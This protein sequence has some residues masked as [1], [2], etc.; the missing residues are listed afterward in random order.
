[1]ATPHTVLAKARGVFCRHCGKPI[2]LSASLLRRET[3]IKQNEAQLADEL[4]SKTFLARCRRCH[5]EAIYSLAQIV[6]FPQGGSRT[7]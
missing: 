5:R 1:M 2:H 4:Y 3:A 7:S 6:D